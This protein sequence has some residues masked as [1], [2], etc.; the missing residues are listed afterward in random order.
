MTSNNYGNYNAQQQHKQISPQISTSSSPSHEL[1]CFTNHIDLNMTHGYASMDSSH[2]DAGRK[3]TREAM[4]KYLKEKNDNVVIIFNAKVAQK[5]YGSEKRFFC[6]PPCVYLMGDGWNRKRKQLIE[7]GE[8]EE[9]TQIA[10][11]I[12]IGN[13]EREMQPLILDNKVKKI[14]KYI[15]IKLKRASV[16]KFN[17]NC[18]VL[19]QNPGQ[20]IRKIT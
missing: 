18:W 9:S 15:S 14:K 1:Q 7:S 2:V 19:G 17:F 6:P 12:G 11:L 3:L 13:S 4:R 8:T 16:F 5:S 20:F 10:T